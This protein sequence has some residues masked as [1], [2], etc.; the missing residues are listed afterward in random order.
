MAFVCKLL[1]SD[2]SWIQRW[3]ATSLSSFRELHLCGLPSPEQLQAFNLRLTMPARKRR[4]STEPPAP[5]P[6]EEDGGFKFRKV[7]KKGAAKAAAA[8]AAP[9][10]ASVPAPAP[11]PERASR[12]AS[13]R[14]VRAAPAATDLPP[15]AAPVVE[16]PEVVEA[17]PGVSLRGAS[18]ELL[19]ATMEVCQ[20]KQAEE[21]AGD[22]LPAMAR[23]IAACV[24]EVRQLGVLQAEV[25]GENAQLRA[26]EAVLQQRLAELRDAQRSWEAVAQVRKSHAIAH[27]QLRAR[28]RRGAAR[29]RTG[30]GARGARA[31]RGRVSTERPV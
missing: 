8:P 31:G 19:Q 20:Q 4:N 24:A 13:S 6:T 30:R 26:R 22:E 15:P 23:A 9:P 3:I 10:P 1:P 11:A 28:A 5:A 12:R 21:G 16:E 17:V 25:A 18:D 2:L 14:A 7:A 27:A 29:A